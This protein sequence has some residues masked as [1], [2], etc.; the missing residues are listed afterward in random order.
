MAEL[1]KQLVAMRE[2]AVGDI[3]LSVEQFAVHLQTTVAALQ[4]ST[5][6]LIQS[7]KSVIYRYLFCIDMLSS[8][9]FSSLL[10]LTARSQ[11]QSCVPE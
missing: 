10:S 9:Q 6:E 11:R 1:G 7:F 5:A 3:H 2:E 8:V 4:D